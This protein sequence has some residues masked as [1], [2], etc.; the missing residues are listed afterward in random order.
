MAEQCIAIPAFPP[1]PPILPLTITPPALPP[2]DLTINYCCRLNLFLFVPIPP[3]PTLVITS[4]TVVAILA[5]LTV[6][7]DTIS[8]YLDALPLSCPFD[9]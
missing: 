4:P 5:A 8:A 9:T 3:L 1:L 2:L 7:M 6:A